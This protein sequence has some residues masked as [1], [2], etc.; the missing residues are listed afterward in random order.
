MMILEERRLREPP[1]ISTQF[2]YRESTDGIIT[3]PFSW[4]LG[5]PLLYLGNRK[6]IKRVFF[7][8]KKKKKERGVLAIHPFIT[9]NI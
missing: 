3:V 6:R 4:L 2:A 9:Y 7:S 5:R 1:L 8:H